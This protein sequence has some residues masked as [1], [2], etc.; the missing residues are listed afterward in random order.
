LAMGQHVGQGAVVRVKKKSRRRPSSKSTFEK[1]TRIAP[2]VL[3]DVGNGH[4]GA[5][6][7][8]PR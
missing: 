4:G 1:L 3:A 7:P 5:Q 6:D 8:N 2:L